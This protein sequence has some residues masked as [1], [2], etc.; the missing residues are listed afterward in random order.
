[1]PPEHD[2][3]RP[4][5]ERPQVSLAGDR[6]SVPRNADTSR[7]PRRRLE[8]IIESKHAAYVRGYG[9]R[10]L[11][12]ELRGRPPVWAT[13]TRAW[14]TTERFARDVIAMAESRGYQVDVESY[15]T[16]K[17]RR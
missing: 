6:T 2:R 7:K 13:I 15:V 16:V 9:S 1:M 3:G 5:E 8:V 17:V 14:V 10:E 4:G 11:L 12:T